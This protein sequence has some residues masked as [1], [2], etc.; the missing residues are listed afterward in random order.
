MVENVREGP[1]AK[2]ALMF[3][4]LV[5]A[6]A[7]LGTGAYEL[8]GGGQKAIQ[9]V[10]NLVGIG[11]A[12]Y[13]LG[14]GVADVMKFVG[15]EVKVWQGA[16]ETVAGD[17]ADVGTKH[18]AQGFRQMGRALPIPFKGAIQDLYSHLLGE[19]E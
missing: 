6:N 18:M 4:R 15:G 5:M 7:A 11:P 13:G 2:R 14:P 12:L 8:Y 9:K 19:E 3:G 10:A 16:V 17:D 1:K